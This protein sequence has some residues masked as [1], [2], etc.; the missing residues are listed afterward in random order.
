MSD[1]SNPQ[2]TPLAVNAMHIR[3]M[4]GGAVEIKLRTGNTWY[5]VAAVSLDSLPVDGLETEIF[6]TKCY[7]D[8]RGLFWF[9]DSNQG[10]VWKIGKAAHKLFYNKKL[11]WYKRVFA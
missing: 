6:G 10:G 1:H 3:R 8:D 5:I 11:S 7:T 2:T 9:W 4:T